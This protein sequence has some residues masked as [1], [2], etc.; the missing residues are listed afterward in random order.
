MVLCVVTVVCG[1]K[2]MS[3]LLLFNGFS[4]IPFTELLLMGVVVN[5]MLKCGLK[6]V[7]IGFV[8]RFENDVEES[9]EHDWNDA[10]NSD[11]SFK[12]RSFGVETFT[13]TFT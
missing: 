7:C 11:K 1:F 4:D 10:V 2:G 13:L 9:I 8:E 5:G 12:F 3:G 6:D